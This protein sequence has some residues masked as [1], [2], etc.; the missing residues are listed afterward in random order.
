[1]VANFENNMENLSFEGELSKA[2][3]SFSYVVGIFK[4][5]N[6]ILHRMVTKD[7]TDESYL[8]IR[9]VSIYIGDI[10]KRVLVHRNSIVGDHLPD[11]CHIV[12]IIGICNDKDKHNVTAKRTLFE[13]L[14]IEVELNDLKPIW[15]SDNR[16]HVSYLYRIHETLEEFE[17]SFANPKIGIGG[18]CPKRYRQYK[19]FESKSLPCV[20]H[21]SFN[22]VSLLDGDFVVP[23]DKKKWNWVLLRPRGCTAVY[24]VFTWLVKLSKDEQFSIKNSSYL[25]HVHV[26]HKQFDINISTA[27]SVAWSILN[28]G[29]FENSFLHLGKIG[30]SLEVC[31]NENMHRF[32]P[33]NAIPYIHLEN[34]D[35]IDSYCKHPD[36]S[37]DNEEHYMTRLVAGPLVHRLLPFLN[38][39]LRNFYYENPRI[40]IEVVN[41]KKRQRE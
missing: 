33:V 17:K 41:K 11:S 19:S 6:H 4:D 30:C 22:D 1:M 21:L 34:A 38:E 13:Q 39:M 16:K 27:Q 25:R 29:V 5:R 3:G 31:R 14:G 26:H 20:Y 24:N 40:V 2:R 10:N 8:G 18:V 35:D 28:Y 32:V 37:S 15:G 12:P 7:L 23:K 9:S 36:Y